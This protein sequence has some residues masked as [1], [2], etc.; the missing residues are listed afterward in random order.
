MASLRGRPAGEELRTGRAAVHR[1]LLAG[2]DGTSSGKVIQRRTSIVSFYRGS[3]RSRPARPLG[4]GPLPQTGGAAP[5][6]TIS[7]PRRDFPLQYLVVGMELPGRDQR[8][9]QIRL[10]HNIVATCP[11]GRS[12]PK[13]RILHCKKLCL[14]VCAPRHRDFWRWRL[15]CAKSKQ[16][17]MAP[18][19]I[20]R[21]RRDN[22]R[23]F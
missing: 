9:D 19:A 11:E 5:P 7:S 2:G 17:A 14:I 23:E 22:G 13:S 21:R 4:P 6:F 12:I 20:D 18:V 10:A 3:R 1:A 15:S 16:S 8:P